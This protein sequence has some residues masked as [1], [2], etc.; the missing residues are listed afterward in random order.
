MPSK[1]KA[2]PRLSSSI[3]QL[4]LR[5][6]LAIITAALSFLALP[7]AAESAPTWGPHTTGIEYADYMEGPTH[8][9]AAKIDLCAPGISMRATAPGEGPRTPSSFGQMVGASVAINGDW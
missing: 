8:V 2:V 3:R 5:S 1:T 9:Y 6:R 7:Q 4:R